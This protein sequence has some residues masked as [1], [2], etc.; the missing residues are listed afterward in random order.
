MSA[1]FGAAPASQP[2][3][4]RVAAGAD[5]F[6]AAATKVA[7]PRIVLRVMTPSDAE[8]VP[9]P[10]DPPPPLMMRTWT[11]KAAFTSG[12]WKSE[13]LAGLDRNYFSD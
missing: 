7:D 13:S 8:M 9:K 6:R 10:R 12:R 1:R 2:P 11:T 3:V 5:T 4:V